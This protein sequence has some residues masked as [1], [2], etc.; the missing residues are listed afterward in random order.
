MAPGPCSTSPTPWSII[1]R[2]V[3]AAAYFRKAFIYGRSGHRY[4]SVVTS[5]PLRHAER[6]HVFRD[7][8]ASAGLSRTESGYL[9]ALLAAG[10]TCYEAGWHTCWR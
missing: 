1:S 7:T 2:F 9:F 6:M 10:V 8:V 5:R 3:P 4:S